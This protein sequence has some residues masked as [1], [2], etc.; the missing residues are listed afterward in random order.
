MSKL[1]I[2]EHPMIVLPSLAQAIGLHEAIILQQLHYWLDHVGPEG[3]RYGAE[4]DG[5]RWIRN[6]VEQWQREHFGFL[7]INQV[8]RAF[9]NLE[10]EKLV[11]SR[12]D[13]NKRGYDRTK[14]YTVDYAIL[15]VRE[16][17]FAC[18]RNAIRASAETIPETT[19]EIKNEEEEEGPENIFALYESTIG[20]IVPLMADELKDA[21]TRFPFEWIREAFAGAVKA[22]ARNWNYV[23]AI[24][25][26]WER[27]GYKSDNR[28][29]KNGNGSK[30]KRDYD[31]AGVAWLEKRRANAGS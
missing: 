24:L 4:K 6:T 15:H 3:Q 22:N 13:L 2:E 14:W 28:A 31:A 30:P 9:E 1:L 11:K 16:M 10:R 17:E 27:E 25:D 26:R 5:E 18:T 29:K 12:K 23:Y 20:A 21:E 8:Y 19:T 7:T